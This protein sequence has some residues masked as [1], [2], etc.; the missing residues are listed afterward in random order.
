MGKI[1]NHVQG[2]GRL[3]QNWTKSV[4]EFSMPI[5]IGDSGLQSSYPYTQEQYQ[6]K[7]ASSKFGLLL[8]DMDQNA[9]EI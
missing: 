8:L 9:I 5:R 6:D 4:E 7:L 2:S 1:E 3:N